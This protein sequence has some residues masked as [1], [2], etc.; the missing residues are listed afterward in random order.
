M[1]SGGRK[2]ARWEQMVNV[3]EFWG[4][5]SANKSIALR[6]QGPYLKFFWFLFSP[7][8]DHQNSE[9]EYILRSVGNEDN[10]KIFFSLFLYF[11]MSVSTFVL[12]SASFS[13][14][15]H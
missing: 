14:I 2:R 9:F 5:S 4:K 10:M 3:N 13:F 7:N 8:T 1:I 6:E 15:Q 11:S 12:F